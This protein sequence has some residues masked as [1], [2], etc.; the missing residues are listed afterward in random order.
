MERGDAHYAHRQIGWAI[1]APG[2]LGFAGAALAL[3]AGSTA[4]A[5]AVAAGL[6]LVLLLFGALTVRV[7]AAQV[8]ISF[9]IG[10]IRKR[11]ALAEVRSCRSVRNSWLAGW[12]IRV[13]RGV[14]LYNVSGLDAVELIFASGRRVR[15]G[16]DEPAALH[17]A[18]AQVVGACAP[19]ADLPAP[20]PG[21]GAAAALALV[22]VVP[23]ALGLL[24]ALEMR[25]P[26]V[27][28]AHGRLDVASTLYSDSV[29]LDDATAVALLAE[30]PPGG[31]RTNGFALAGTLRGHFRLDGFGDGMVFAEVDAPPYILVRTRQSYLL[32]GFGDPARTRALFERIQKERSR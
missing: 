17:D 24:F 20:A 21:R 2:A 18:I 8:R 26:R 9:G 19:L 32:L 16:T 4:V 14:V 25:E 31:T 23:G 7:D 29:S 30:P 27:T 28:L 1:I 3:R 13:G 5:G 10:A 15:I 12:G 22:A 6:A 11:F